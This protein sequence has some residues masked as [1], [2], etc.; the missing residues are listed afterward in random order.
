MEKKISSSAF[1]TGAVLFAVTAAAVL[2]GGCQQAGAGGITSETPGLFNHYVVYPFSYLIKAFAGLFGGSYGLSI[3]VITLLIRFCLM[4]LMVRQTKMSMNL[5]EQMAVIQPE[6]KVI[7]EKM[8]RAKD[9]DAKTKLQQ[10]MMQLYQAK[11]INPLASLGGCLPMLLQLPI[12]M[13]FYYA[14]QQ[15]PDI[16]AHSFLWFNLGSADRI[17]PLLAGVIYYIQFK[18]SL[19]TMD[20]E[21]RKQMAVLGYLSPVM[22]AVF[23]F[24]VPAAIPLYWCVG[25]IFIIA[26]TW[27]IQKMYSKKPAAASVPLDQS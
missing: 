17:L 26:Q 23:S 9:T 16:A 11:G 1:K 15:T 2:L 6:M 18:V 5:K 19:I 21:Q 20:A 3:I 13:G 12:L 4:P 10:E 8:K 7:Q 22:M 27:F 14:I 24:S 25:G